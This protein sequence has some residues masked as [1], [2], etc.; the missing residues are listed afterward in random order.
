MRQQMENITN[1]IA[2]KIGIATN[3]E[4]LFAIAKEQL[5]EVY[6][7]EDNEED[8]ENSGWGVEYTTLSIMKNDVL[9]EVIEAQGVYKK[10]ELDYLQKR[11]HNLK[12]EIEKQGSDTTQ[13]WELWFKLDLSEEDDSFIVNCY[14]KYKVDTYNLVKVDCNVTSEDLEE[15]EVATKLEQRLMFEILKDNAL[16]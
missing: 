10:A 4:E 11:V 9:N 2:K 14:Y 15:T 1:W 3:Y 5:Q 12:I 13:D 8:D 16:D 7:D 6:G